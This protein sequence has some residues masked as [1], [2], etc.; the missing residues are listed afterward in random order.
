MA[1][2]LDDQQIMT[3]FQLLD[4][5]NQQLF[6]IIQGKLPVQI[7]PG[8]PPGENH[9]RHVPD[10]LVQPIDT[11]H[12]GRIHVHGQPVVRDAFGADGLDKADPRIFFSRQ[13]HE[14]DADG[15]LAGML[16]GC[17]DKYFFT[18][19][20]TPLVR[21]LGLRP[22]L[23]QFPPLEEI[24]GPEELVILFHLIVGEIL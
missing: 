2:P 7:F 20:V 24:E 4:S 9:W 16:P 11:S 19:E 3:L 5:G 6:L 8:G 14:R 23:E 22:L 12:E 1:G 21:S 17:R 18:H 13:V 15:G 10:I